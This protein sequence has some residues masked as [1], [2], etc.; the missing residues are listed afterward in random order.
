VTAFNVPPWI[1][2]PIVWA[3]VLGF[4]GFICGFF[5]AGLLLADM[6]SAAP[7]L[8]IIVVGPIALLGVLL[9]ALSASLRIST[10]QNLVFLAIAAATITAGTLYLAVSEYRQTDCRL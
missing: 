7:L 2:R 5:G 1:T 4:F 9:G 8:G 6:G 10:R 3:G